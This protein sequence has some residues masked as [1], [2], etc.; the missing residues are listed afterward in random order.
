MCLVV[1]VW[2]APQSHISR[3]EFRKRRVRYLGRRIGHFIFNWGEGDTE[4]Q[5]RSAGCSPPP[6]RT[7]RSSIEVADSESLSEADSERDRV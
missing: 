2:K 1:L 4:R 5:R 7:V 6:Y 3:S